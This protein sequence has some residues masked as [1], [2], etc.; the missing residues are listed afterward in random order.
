MIKRLLNELIYEELGININCDI[1][2]TG[3]VEDER[4]GTLSYLE[5]YKYLKTLNNNHNIV[6]AFVKN[7]MLKKLRSSIIPIVVEKPAATFF[8]IH[9]KY[10]KK[11]L[12]YPDSEISKSAYIAPN[13]FIAP[14]GVIIGENVKIYS[15]ATVFEGSEIGDNSSIGP[16]CV[17]GCEGFQFYDDIK[18]TKQLVTHD[19]L[20]KIGDNV[21]IEANSVIFKGLLGRDTIIGD[22]SKIGSLVFI[23]HGVKIGKRSSVAATACL[24]G[25][26]QVGDDVWIGPQSVVS[27]GI[28][29]NDRV[30]IL[31]GAVVIGNVKSDSVVSGNFAVPHGKNLRLM[32]HKL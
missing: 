14:K 22:E 16:G 23:A 4:Q 17:M 10:C 18:G 24:S 30:R 6:A 13:A 28:I 8:D 12:K 25:S 19:G 32:A 7:D 20:I 31:M 9:N 2:F 5:N 15:Q 3:F 27:N 21:D 29:I 11:F 26:V 1:L